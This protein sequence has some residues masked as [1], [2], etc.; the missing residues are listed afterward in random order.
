MLNAR[1]DPAPLIGV[2]PSGTVCPRDRATRLSGG[3]GIHQKWS[4]E[5]NQDR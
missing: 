2:T 3:E 5:E 4:L 1:V